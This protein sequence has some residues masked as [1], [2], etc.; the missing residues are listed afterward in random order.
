MVVS[1]NTRTG[2]TVAG[3]LCPPLAPAPA[4]PQGTSRINFKLQ[5]RNCEMAS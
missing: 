1:S 3:T 4:H 5:R 2:V